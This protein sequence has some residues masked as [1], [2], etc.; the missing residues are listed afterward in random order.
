MKKQMNKKAIGFIAA[1]LMVAGIT[2][3]S[4]VYAAGSPSGSAAALV[5]TKYSVEEMLVYAIEDEYLAQTEY[6]V[7]MEEYGE[8]RP[9]VNIVK[10]EAKHISLLLPLFDEYGV[11]VPKKDW[12]SMVAVPASLEAANEIGVEAEEKNIAMYESFLKEKLPED[13]K[14]VFERL[15][16]AS[17]N[18]LKAFQNTIDGTCTGD[19][20]QNGKSNSSGR[21]C[22]QGNGQGNGGNRNNAKGM[23]GCNKGI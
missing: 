10:A 15:M 22:G 18:H 14:L 12:K 2:T 3:G 8:Q 17:V 6:N 9:Y 23:L 4:V 11:A 5:D 13:V 19:G 20:G 1:S 16:N 21:G 7:I